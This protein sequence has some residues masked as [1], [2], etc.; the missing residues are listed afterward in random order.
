MQITIDQNAT[1]MRA[2]QRHTHTRTHTRTLAHIAAFLHYLCIA[3]LFLLHL[4]CDN[5]KNIQIVRIVTKT[6]DILR[7]RSENFSTL[8]KSRH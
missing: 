8:Q 6:A 1:M 2:Q 5:K 4:Q 7:C 3:T